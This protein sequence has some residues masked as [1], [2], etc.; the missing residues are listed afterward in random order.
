VPNRI[1]VSEMAGAPNG[2]QGATLAAAIAALKPAADCSARFQSARR[3]IMS[4]STVA[5]SRLFKFALGLP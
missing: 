4:D 1:E 5:A 3:A 2:A